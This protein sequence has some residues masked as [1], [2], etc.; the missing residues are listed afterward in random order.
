MFIVAQR[1]VE[2]LEALCGG[3]LEE[4]VQPTLKNVLSQSLMSLRARS[5]HNHHGPVSFTVD[6]EPADHPP[7]LV[8]IILELGYTPQNLHEF[9]PLVHLFIQLLDIF[10]GELSV[11]GY[12]QHRVDPAEP[13]GNSRDERDFRAGLWWEKSGKVSSSFAFVNVVRK[14]IGPHTSTETLGEYLRYGGWPTGRIVG[15]GNCS[16]TT[17]PGNSEN[18]R[19]STWLEMFQQRGY[20]QLSG[21]GVAPGVRDP[22]GLTDCISRVQ[23]CQNGRPEG[24]QVWRGKMFY[25]RPGYRTK[26]YITPYPVVRT[27]N[28]LRTYSPRSSRQ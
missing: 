15:P 13:R 2:V 20:K 25:I 21:G 12:T 9:L 14:R 26:V 27:S 22:L 28:P 8:F 10:S 19:Y 18:S 7:M 16:G 6:L 23:L 17:V 5:T 24:T 3:T 1:E 4:V 11:E